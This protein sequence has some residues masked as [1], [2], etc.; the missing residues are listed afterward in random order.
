MSL[1]QQ[2]VNV[3]YRLQQH[4]NQELVNHIEIF[5][6]E[7]NWVHYTVTANVIKYSS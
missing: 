2:E 5:L 1:F 6:L 3:T 4:Y 7:P